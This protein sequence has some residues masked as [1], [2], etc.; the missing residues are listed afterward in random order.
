MGIVTMMNYVLSA[1][2]NKSVA[3]RNRIYS[4]SS[5]SSTSSLPCP[6]SPL[7]RFIIPLMSAK[8]VGMG[9]HATARSQT[10]LLA[11]LGLVLSYQGWE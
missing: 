7:M 2:R 5:L 6:S 3:S 11:P 9:S 4:A 10:P 8:H 1:S